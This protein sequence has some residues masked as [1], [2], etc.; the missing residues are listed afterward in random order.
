MTGLTDVLIRADASPFMGT[1]HVMRCL[2]L[3]QACQDQGLSVVISGRVNVPWVKA[4]LLAEKIPFVPIL[5]ENVVQEQGADLL[6]QINIAAPKARWVVLDGYHFGPDVQKSVQADGRRLMVIDDYAHLPNYHCDILLNQNIGAETL[7][8]Q[9]EIGERFSGPHYAL[10]RREFRQAAQTA[11]NRPMREQVQNIL[12]TLGGGDFSNHLAE[13]APALAL[14]PKG[15]ALR[16]IG[17]AMAEETIRSALK[18]CPASVDILYNVADMP[19][20]MLW[21]D[22]CVTAGGSTCWELCALGVPFLTVEL[23]ENQRKIVEILEEQAIA[24]RCSAENIVR[25]TSNPK[26]RQ[27]AYARMQALYAGGGMEKI[28]ARLKND[29]K[30][31]RL[32]SSQ[33]KDDLYFIAND[34]TVRANALNSHSISY[35]EHCAWFERTLSSGIPFYIV[36]YK[37]KTCGYVRFSLDG[38]T[39]TTSIAFA[40]DSQGKGLGLWGLKAAMNRLAADAELSDIEAIVIAE[41]ARSSKMFQKAGFHLQKRYRENGKDLIL[42]SFPLR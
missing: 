17:G 42:F 8:Y 38:Q 13:L 34:P 22:L 33:D 11:Q 2:A 19:A 16:V 37:G 35:D 41:N 6:N 5:G 25:L 1:G 30:T 14:L 10:L 18:D 36:E 12:L 4:R 27:D 7:S 9:G 24:P 15:V 29:E 20:L 28:I 31:I 32:V 23:A 21:A 39:A 3:A 26:Q 40:A